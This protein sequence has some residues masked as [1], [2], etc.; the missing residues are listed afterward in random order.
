MGHRFVKTATASYRMVYKLR[1]SER[2]IVLHGLPK[3]ETSRRTR[4]CLHIRYDV[5]TEKKATELIHFFTL[6]LRNKQLGQDSQN[7]YDIF[8]K[9][10]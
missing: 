6:F 10:W 4:R 3:A 8:S 9:V 2:H 7:T 1:N 5:Q